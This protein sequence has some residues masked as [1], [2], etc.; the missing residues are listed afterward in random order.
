[1]KP[2]IGASA[3]PNCKV[4]PQIA[5]HTHVGEHT[6]LFLLLLLTRV[7]ADRPYAVVLAP[8]MPRYV[9]KAAL[10]L[11]EPLCCRHLGVSAGRQNSNGL[12]SAKSDNRSDCR[13]TIA[14]WAF[15]LSASATR[16]R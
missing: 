6:A 8:H 14:L 9:G 15:S 10:A 12:L 2:P 13:T 5:D 16:E 7:L 4:A 11:E 3:A 1:M